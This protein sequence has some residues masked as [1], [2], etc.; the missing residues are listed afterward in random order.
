L[1]LLEFPL[2]DATEFDCNV[3]K[4]AYRQDPL[5]AAGVA[6]ELAS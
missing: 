3:Q 5:I 2:P 1:H 4:I 6:A